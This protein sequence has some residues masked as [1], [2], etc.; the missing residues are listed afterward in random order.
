MTIRGKHLVLLALAWLA[1]LYFCTRE[2][3]FL[4]EDY[5]HLAEARE[6]RTLAQALDPARE[7]LRPLQHLLFWVLSRR[8]DPEPALVHAIGFLLQ[9]ASIVAVWAIARELGLDPLP[10][11]AAALL[12]ALF[13]ALVGLGWSAAIST[14]GRTLFVLL[15]WLSFL[16][17]RAERSPVDGLFFVL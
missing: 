7:P 1:V 13:P 12:F 15:A 4:S 9:A 3:G 16:R 17:W 11:G 10:S 2:V 14:P 8:V 5:T 6:C